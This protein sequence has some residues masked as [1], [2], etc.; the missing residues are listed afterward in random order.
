ME[1]LKKRNPGG[2]RG[3]FEAI[4]QLNNPTLAYRF[5][6]VNKKVVVCLYASNCEGEIS[7]WM[8]ESA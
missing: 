3:A 2:N 8:D 1:L 7:A 4:V 6:I 5:P